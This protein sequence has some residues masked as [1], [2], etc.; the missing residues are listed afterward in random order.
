VIDSGASKSDWVFFDD[1][2]SYH[3]T[4]IGINPVSND[5]TNQIAHPNSEIDAAEVE[6][7]HYYGAGVLGDLAKAKV[8]NQ[9]KS[10]YPNA[11]EVNVNS[12]LLGAA[13][14]CSSDHISIVSILGT[15]S[16]TCLFDGYE[17]KS[18]VPSLGFIF[19]DEG[20]GF[21]I[22]REVIKSFFFGDMPESDRE[23]FIA[24][25]GNEV[26]PILSKI[27][28]AKKPN[29]EVAQY[30]AFLKDTEPEYKHY[31]LERIFNSFLENKVK[32]LKKNSDFP[33]NFVGSIAFHFQDILKKVCHVYGYEV[34][35]ILERPIEKLKEYHQLNG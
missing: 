18:S 24:Q 6:R 26:A 1:Q 9:L 20:S 35:R 23:N 32:P 29:Y 5:N 13:R 33:L 19:G 10:I 8:S 28:S 31:I 3:E 11:T 22:G 16:N 27:Y 15:G 7:I 4:S 25:H 14:A 30:A 17:I 34:N 12:D 2:R 21:S